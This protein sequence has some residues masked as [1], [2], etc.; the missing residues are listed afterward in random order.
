[1]ADIGLIGDHHQEI[2]Q[3]AQGGSLRGHTG[4]QAELF[5]AA[6]RKGLAAAHRR[7]VDDAIAIEE[8]GG[9]RSL[10]H[11]GFSPAGGR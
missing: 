5:Q 2:A 4:E 3:L 8:D 10:G 6:R 11:D 1:M 7:A 9:M